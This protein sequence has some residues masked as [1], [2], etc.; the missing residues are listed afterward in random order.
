MNLTNADKEFVWH[1]YTQMS[2]WAKWNN[3]VIVKGDG[4]YLVDS[5]GRKYLDGTASMW[6]NVWGH[7]QNKVVQAMVDQLKNIPHSTLFG[8]A[9]APSIKLAERLITL[10]TGMEKVFYT[11]NGSTA[12]EVAM[13]I[14]LQYWYN[15]G[16]DKKR[17]FISLEHGYHGDTTGAMSI[18]YIED[19]F[20]AYKPLLF[21]VHRVPSPILYGSR[22]TNESDLVEWC[23]E[24]TENTIKR[25]MNR[26]AAL[27]MESGAQIAGGAIVFPKGYQ[28]K[29]A[30][31]CRDY[32]ILLILD[33][34][35]TGF[36]RLGNVV[37][38]R[39]QKSQPDI[40]C[41]GKALT[42]GYFPLAVTL[43]TRRIFDAF[44]GRY[45]KNKLLYHG[46]T[47]TGH[48]VG[49][50]AALANIENYQNHNLIQ[51]IKVNTKYIASRLPE[52]YKSPIVAD[53]RHKGLL[54]GIELAKNDKPIII[55]KN[56]EIINYFIVQQALKMRVYLRPLRNI[57]LL[58]PPLGIGRRDLEKLVNVQLMLVRKIEKL[59]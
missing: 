31:L 16:K 49:C 39:A 4:F 6:C 48:T 56:K 24:K 22:F 21:N 45:C 29:I 50:S 18:G 19:F 40:V 12:I 2:D 26:C 33:E 47:F 38:Y 30:R 58:I 11:D 44:L 35:A 52:F 59:S 3:K 20:R 1:P 55:L 28:K 43:V 36:G 17:E 14:A 51:Q 8:F 9:N 41:F 32:D 57:M 27:V 23:L 46:H 53:I 42:G 5:Q 54:V 15:N 37:E 13:K 34:I 7:T 10:A 25:H